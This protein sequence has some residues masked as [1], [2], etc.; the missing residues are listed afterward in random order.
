MD[1]AS[2]RPFW[3]PWAAGTALGLTLLLTFL[4]AGHGLGASGFFTSL[5]AALG[6]YIAPA[7]TQASRYFGPYLSGNPLSGWIT[8]EVLGLLLGA[9]AGSLTAGRFHLTIERGEGVSRSRRLLYAFLGGALVGFGS[10]LARGCTSGLG[11]SGGA[12]LSVGAF[13]FLITFFIAGFAATIWA[14]R[15]WR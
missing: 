13:V 12:A 10:R 4:L 1:N 2:P 3:P 6:L 7:T 5:T 8:W 14:R 11:L 9:L 15:I